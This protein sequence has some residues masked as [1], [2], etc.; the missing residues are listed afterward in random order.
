MP[1]GSVAV[2][3]DAQGTVISSTDEAISRALFAHPVDLNATHLT[4]GKDA[5]GDGW[6]FALAEVRDNDLYIAFAQR[7]RALFA[8]SY[9]DLGA[10]VA[11]PLLM[12]L[13]AFGA[14]WY[15]ADRFVL[16]WIAYLQR[17]ARSYA[18]GHYTVRPEKGAGD[19]PAEIQQLAATMGEM[20]EN[21]QQRDQ[22]LRQALE[23]R[24][25]MIREIHH[26][27]K[28]NLQIVASLLDLEARRVKE[29]SARA[30]L[31]MT[32][33]R[34]NAIALANRVLEEVDAQTVV[35]LR[36]M[37]REL[38][39]LLHD[40]F[41]RGRDIQDIAVDAP[42]ILLETDIA[43]P[44]AL[45]LVEQLADIYRGAIEGQAR[46]DLR[47]FAESAGE[48]VAVTILAEGLGEP[49]AKAASSFAA[50]YVRQLGAEAR[51]EADSRRSVISLR[52]PRT[53]N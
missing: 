25:L 23:Q 10:N 14:I 2:L 12:A 38:A 53:K 21:I 11:L 51:I 19:A 27:V 37:L 39:M 47:L 32:H 46:I 16:R 22:G 15:S 43:V 6:M 42:D 4:R 18:H 20:A 30:A 3:L 49:A 40:A 45:W 48:D 33:T 13:F 44:L 35:N 7:E 24:K 9:I 50:A 41:G 36:T 26:R 28:N 31:T 29:P 8:W 17:V 1:A 5:S 52:F 34:I